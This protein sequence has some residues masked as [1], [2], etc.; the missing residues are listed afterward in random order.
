MLYINFF[1]DNRIEKYVFILWG[2]AEFFLTEKFVKTLILR[3]KQAFLGSVLLWGLSHM[4]YL[5]FYS[6]FE[7]QVDKI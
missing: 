1:I 6:N 4:R 3:E 7:L 2:K 5:T